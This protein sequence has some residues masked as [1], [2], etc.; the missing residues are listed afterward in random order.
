MIELAS[1]HWN[2]IIVTGDFNINLLDATSANCKLIKIFRDAGLKQVINT[3]TREDKNPYTLL[4][5]LYTTHEDRTSEI[6]VPIYGLSD[7]YPICF[8][9]KFGRGKR[10]KNHHVIKLRTETLRTFQK[11]ILFRI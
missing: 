1:C 2:E 8:M 10:G 7:H 11:K 6:I 4:D 9:H 5:H 3:A